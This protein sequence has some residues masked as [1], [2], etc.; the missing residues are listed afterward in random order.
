M[1]GGEICISSYKGAYITQTDDD[2]S[3]N[4]WVSFGTKGTGTNQFTEPFGIVVH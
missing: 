2:M 1:S 4:N 3:G